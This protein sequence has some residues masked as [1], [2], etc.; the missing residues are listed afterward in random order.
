MDDKGETILFISGRN[1]L[2]I[3]D[4]LDRLDRQQ[5]AHL[6]ARIRSADVVEFTLRWNDSEPP[7]EPDRRKGS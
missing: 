1:V 2:L 5:A 7:F 6:A 4:A 3:C